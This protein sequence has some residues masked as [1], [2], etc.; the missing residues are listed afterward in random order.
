[1]TTPGTQ[2]G[3]HGPGPR[4]DFRVAAT[5][6]LAASGVVFLLPFA[7]NN[8]V[9]GRPL[10]GAGSLSIIA[11]LAINAWAASRG[12]YWPWV[13]LV[14]TVPAVLF[15]LALAF[16]KQGIIGALWCY[17]AVFVIY[18]MLP[19]RMA[20]GAN[21]AL[22]GVAIPAAWHVLDHGVAVRVAVTL[23]VVSTFSALLI[24]IITSQQRRLQA[25]AI[26]DPLTG[27]ANRSTLEASLAQAIEQA[28]HRGQPVSLLALDIDHFKKIN[29]E[30][31]HEAGDAVLR[32]LGGLLLE[33]TRRADRVFRLGGEEFLVLLNGTRAA[34]GR[35]FAEH[36]REE[37]EA[38]GL[39]PDMRVTVSIGVAELRP[40][41]DTASWMKR[42]DDNL[43]RAKSG[44]RNRVCA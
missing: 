36:L 8:F 28:R 17:P 9:Q 27:V 38:R 3:T 34:D 37:I 11:F 12:R 40:D 23:S 24:R 16:L 7:I 42:A 29:D 35:Q 14:G 6:W 22:L 5:F 20:W 33:R 13:M 2:G 31:G 19:E 41:E 43:Y 10:L 18:F 44:G 15:F 39:L 32:G 1:V 26:T 4:T 25:Q 30:R 21:V